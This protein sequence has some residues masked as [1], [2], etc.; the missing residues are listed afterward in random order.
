MEGIAVFLDTWMEAASD[1]RWGH[2]RR[3]VF[4]S[5]VRD[6]SRFYDPLG[7]SPELDVR[8]LRLEANSYLYG[9]RFMEYLAIPIRRVAHPVGVADRK[10]A[11]RTTRR[12]SNRVYDPSLERDGVVD[13][14]AFERDFQTT[15]SRGGSGRIDDDLSRRVTTG[16]RVACRALS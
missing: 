11:A 8:R 9:T 4:R 16:A 10:G 7:L 6:G 1:A 13:W 14:I 2:Y 15:I 12:S 5:M 3:D